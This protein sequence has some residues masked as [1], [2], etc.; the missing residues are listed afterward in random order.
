[1]DVFI[2]AS[3]KQSYSS[4]ADKEFAKKYALVSLYHHVTV[5]LRRRLRVPRG[6]ERGIS[7]AIISK[8]ADHPFAAGDRLFVFSEGAMRCAGLRPGIRPVEAAQHGCALHMIQRAVC[9]VVQAAVVGN[10]K[11]AA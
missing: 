10:G 11:S 8:T 3:A 2:T 4:P 7:E 5:Q 6:A 9:I 1:M